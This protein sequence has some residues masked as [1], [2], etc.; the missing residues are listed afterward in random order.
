MAKFYLRKDKNGNFSVSMPDVYGGGRR[1]YHFQHYGL[2]FL[3]ENIRKDIAALADVITECKQGTSVE[4]RQK[5][6][7]LLEADKQNYIELLEY[8]QKN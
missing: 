2:H 4:F 1:M 5:D 7:A 6:I 8:L 3:I